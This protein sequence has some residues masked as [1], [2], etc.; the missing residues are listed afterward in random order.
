MPSPH[1]AAAYQPTGNHWGPTDD[2]RRLV[3]YVTG[4]TSAVYRRVSLSDMIRSL[5]LHAYDIHPFRGSGG[6]ALNAFV[7]Y[8]LIDERRIRYHDTDILTRHA[9][10]S[11]TIDFNG[12][13][14]MST[15]E[16]MNDGFKYL[17]LPLRVCADGKD[18]A[19][20][21][22]MPFDGNKGVT[23]IG[24]EPYTIGKHTIA[25]IKGG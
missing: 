21:Y 6:R 9:D 15:R 8:S 12:W 25:A 11:V 18:R 10:G 20:L 22:T 4:R 17:G 19:A 13:H 7:A 14:T 2:G 23:H 16:R 1:P 5:P 3:N 24:N